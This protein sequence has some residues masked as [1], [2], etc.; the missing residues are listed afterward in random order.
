MAAQRTRAGKLRALAAMSFVG[1]MLLAGSAWFIVATS[2]PRRREAD[3]AD[4]AE[5]P[6]AEESSNW[7]LRQF[8][9]EVNLRDFVDMVLDEFR[10]I[11]ESLRLA[12]EPSSR[13]IPVWVVVAALV[14]LVLLTV[15]VAVIGT[16]VL[17]ITVIRA[18][19]RNP[20]SPN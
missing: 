19:A 9:D 2:G 13:R 18:V 11:V 15:V 12:A 17:G 3:T 6:E 8:L 1:P 20:R 16:A 10:L 7:G 14:R 5:T 4:A